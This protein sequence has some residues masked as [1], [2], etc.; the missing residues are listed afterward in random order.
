MTNKDMENKLSMAQAR[1]SS[2]LETANQSIQLLMEASE[3]VE[4]LYTEL[5]Y[6][7]L[8]VVERKKLSNNDDTAKQDPPADTET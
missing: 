3:L 2:A 6:P 4:K 5:L 8:Q 1:I 7:D